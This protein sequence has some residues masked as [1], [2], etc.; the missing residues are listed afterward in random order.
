[1]DVVKVAP[2]M[3]PA[4]GLGDVALGIEPVEAGV[5]VGLQHTMER[6]EMGAWVEG[7]AV[8]A[9]TVAHGGRRRAG[10]RPLIAQIGPEP[11]SPGLAGARRQHRD[12]RVIRI[13]TISEHDM[14]LQCIDQRAQQ[15]RGLTD[16][17][18]EGRA[19]QRDTGSTVD[20]ALPI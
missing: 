9:V 14:P 8:G 10:I 7:P 16:P 19:L 13:E 2:D 6:S 4:G 3:R 15:R 1:M 5:A 11:T 18:G 17:V 12:G 20:L